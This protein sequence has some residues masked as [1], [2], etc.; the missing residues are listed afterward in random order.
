MF[1]II[2]G[3]ISMLTAL[4]AVW[5]SYRIYI[6]QRSL[7]NENHF[8]RYKID[9]YQQLINCA[10]DLIN[11]YQ[12][13]IDQ[14]KYLID[15]AFDRRDI[16]KL[17]FELDG[18]TNEFR[19]AL[20]KFTLFIPQKILAKLEGFYDMLYAK[21]E[22]LEDLKVNLDVSKIEEQIDILIDKLDEIIGMMREDIGVDV[23][24]QKLNKRLKI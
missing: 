23:I 15:T 11:V 18:K 21:L 9:Q 6:R 10:S 12:E 2:A 13:I 14:A 1:T 16:D 19:K 8:F 20:S 3:S 22:I 4:C 5:I 7:D 17:A 24:N